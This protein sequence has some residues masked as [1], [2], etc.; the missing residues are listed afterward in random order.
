MYKKIFLILFSFLFVHQTFSILKNDK[1]GIMICN[2]KL[3]SNIHAQNKTFHNK[4]CKAIYT[5]VIAI[6]FAS[7]I[8]SK[9]CNE[10]IKK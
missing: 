1:H 9:N 4:S 10:I 6:I 2:K 3:N 5:I 7:Y 8:H